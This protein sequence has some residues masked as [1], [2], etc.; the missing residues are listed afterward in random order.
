MEKRT[1]G[2]VMSD[3]DRIYDISGDFNMCEN[4]RTKEGQFR[5]EMCNKVFDYEWSEE[6]A[7]AEAKESGFDVNDCGRV[8]ADCY[9]LTPWGQI[10]QLK[11]ENNK[12]REVIQK[13]LDDEESGNGWGPDNTVCKYLRDSLGEDK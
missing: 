2:I 12:M 13:V 8:C 1:R 7:Q 11:A 6:E 4:E 5:C 10:E 9:K 3:W